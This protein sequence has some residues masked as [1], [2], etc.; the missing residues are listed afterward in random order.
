MQLQFD[1]QFLMSILFL[2]FVGLLC[3]LY[4]S[5]VDKPNRL[6][7]KLMKQGISGPPPTILLGNI[8]ELQK[9]RSATSK[10]SSSSSKVPSS[11][12][13]AA[14][15]LP[16]FDKWRNEYGQV[17]V[18]SLG[19]IQIVC[20]N[21]PDI[22]RE[23]T[24]CTSLDMGKPAYQLKHIGP[25]VGQGILTSNGTKWVH[26]RKIIAP[27]LY[28]EKVKGMMNI[29][30]ESAVSV[31]NSWSNRIEAEGGVAD[32]KIDEC[33]RNFSGNV[34][35]RACFGS[36]YTK[37]EEIFLK[38]TALQE[39]LSWKN[40]F[41][42]IP[43]MCYLPTKTNREIWTLEKEVNEMILQVVKERKETSFEKDLL[44]MVLENV[45]DSKPSK[46]AI[47][48]FIVDNCKN[49]YLAG[50]ET[51]AV[52]ATWCLMLLAAN[53]DWQDRVRA[54][55]TE[56]CRGRIP[57]FSMLGKMKQLAMVIHEV[58]RLYPPVTVVSREALKDMKFGNL[59]VPK[60]FNLWIM[61]VSL[62]TNPDIWGD[63]AYKFK[64]ERF[65]N[66]TIGSCKLP[67][68]YMPFGV[69]PRVC[70]GQNL[71]IVELKMIIALILSKFTFSLSPRYVHS[72]TLRLLIEPEHGVNIL[73]K[74][75]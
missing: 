45:K 42:R 53:P 21:Q 20:V 25:L 2:S 23:V 68:V 62:H 15:L 35:S 28:M 48:D 24:V 29:I 64:P 66:G 58:L 54:E 49:I 32:I 14:L 1:S 75:I 6:R 5:F 22:V 43:G 63:D 41:R 61:V 39:L 73:V 44:Q 34:I 52:S 30:S 16:L 51:T 69:G 59:D 13:C 18:F 36:N 8:L 38:L 57:D 50:Y 70:L 27:E 19:T 60:G 46:E 12:N 4:T 31:V 56:I 26:Q 9:A 40:L 67:H 55:V 72:P 10:S 74:K 65:A 7:S 47:D 17:F 71:A 33:M 3:Y 11:H 37:S